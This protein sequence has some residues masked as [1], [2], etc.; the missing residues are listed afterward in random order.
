MC[1]AGSA[2]L[3]VPVLVHLLLK[4]QTKRFRFTR[5][6]L[7]PNNTSNP[8]SGAALQ[9]AVAHAA[10]AHLHAA[11]AGFCSAHFLP[12][13]G[14]AGARSAN[15]VVI[16]LDRSLSMQANAHEG[17]QWLRARESARQILSDLGPDDRA[18]LVSCSTR[19]RCSR[20]GRQRA[21]LTNWSPSC[22]RPARRAA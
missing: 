6:I 22:N 13:G 2:A 9:L 11:G 16:V 12:D 5:A 19:W 20:S 15:G 3:S 18:A 10:L 14:V 8:R 17:P 4:R 1:A 7:Y 21:E